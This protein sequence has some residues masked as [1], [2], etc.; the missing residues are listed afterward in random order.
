VEGG[1]QHVL[2][3]TSEKHDRD[4]VVAHLAAEAFRI[5]IVLLENLF[6]YTNRLRAK[7]TDTL[8]ICASRLAA[9]SFRP[10]DLDRAIV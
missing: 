1:L 6:G 3:L 9:G 5:M 7:G 10:A 8:L 2:T 4:L